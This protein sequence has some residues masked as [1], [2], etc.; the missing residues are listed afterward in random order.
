[1][2]HCP[3]PGIVRKDWLYSDSSSPRNAPARRATAGRSARPDQVLLLRRQNTGLLERS[4][5]FCGPGNV[6]QGRRSLLVA[7]TLTRCLRDTPTL[8]SLQ[9][10]CAGP[11]KHFS[12]QLPPARINPSKGSRFWFQKWNPPGLAGG[13]F[14]PRL[15]R[16]FRSLE[17]GMRRAVNSSGGPRAKVRPVFCCRH[18]L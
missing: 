8:V 7:S 11:T 17:S 10:P 9:A 2:D 14:Q 1:M 15:P 13:S 3:R 5:S 4:Q 16:V 6:V 12:S 18:L